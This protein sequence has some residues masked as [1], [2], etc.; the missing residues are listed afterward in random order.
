MS[1]LI[2]PID[3]NHIVVKWHSF[4]FFYT[5]VSSP[6]RQYP[7]PRS[8]SV[9]AT[10]SSILPHFLDSRDPVPIPEPGR[11]PVYISNDHIYCRA[12]DLTRSKIEELKKICKISDLRYKKCT[13]G[14]YMEQSQL[15][16]DWMMHI[17]RQTNDDQTCSERLFFVNSATKVTTWELPDRAMCTLKIQ[18]PDKYNFVQELLLKQN[19]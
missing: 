11:E 5:K 13:C 15:V 16:D 18:Q 17:D 14:L 2:D 10:G 1:V 8:N 19:S 3:K 12:E 6:F 9:S 7:P 4:V